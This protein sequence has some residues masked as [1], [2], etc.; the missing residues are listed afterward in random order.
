MFGQARIQLF[1]GFFLT[2]SHANPNDTGIH[3]KAIYSIEFLWMAKGRFLFFVV[4]S[5]RLSHSYF[6]G[7]FGMTRTGMRSMETA[8]I[9]YFLYYDINDL[10]EEIFLNIFRFWNYNILTILV[11]NNSSNPF[12][13]TWWDGDAVIFLI[14]AAAFVKKKH[15]SF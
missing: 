1:V 10:L 2:I 9:L 13:L 7:K 5:V 12:I 3:I 11:V 15:K 6:I 4:N 14:Y 8:G